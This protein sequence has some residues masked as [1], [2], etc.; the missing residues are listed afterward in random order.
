MKIGPQKYKYFCNLQ[1]YNFLNFSYFSSSFNMDWNMAC[2]I[3]SRILNHKAVQKVATEK[4]SISLSANKM[5]AAFIT[6]RKSPS[7]IMVTGSVINTRNGL[8]SK[9]SNAMTKATITAVP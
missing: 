7:V 5:M 2:K 4:P 9:L 1:D 6:R 3:E 8:T